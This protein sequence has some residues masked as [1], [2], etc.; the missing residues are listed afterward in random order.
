M[1]KKIYEIYNNLYEKDNCNKSYTNLEG[2]FVFPF[3]FSPHMIS[4]MAH[5]PGNYNIV[6]LHKKL[7]SVDIIIVYMH[8][9]YNHYFAKVERISFISVYME[10]RESPLYTILIISWPFLFW[11]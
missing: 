4:I 1:P 10:E 9:K 3:P 6:K 11:E 5:P 2:Y 7:L 8:M